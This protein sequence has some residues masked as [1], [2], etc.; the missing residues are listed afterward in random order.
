MTNLKGNVYVRIHTYI[1]IFKHTRTI[2]DLL[3][4][5]IVKYTG[6]FKMIHPISND[7]IFEVYKYRVFSD[8][9]NQKNYCRS[10]VP[11][12]ISALCDFP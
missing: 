12:L 3:C 6:L 5:D 9:I 7:Y 1:H 2:H 10:F 11:H 8:N 4:C